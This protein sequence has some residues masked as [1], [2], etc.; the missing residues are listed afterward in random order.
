MTSFIE[1]LNVSNEDRFKKPTP[2]VFRRHKLLKAL[3]EQIEVATEYMYGRQYMRRSMRTVTDPET[4]QRISVMQQR[5]ARK[6]FWVDDQG[7]MLLQIRYGNRSIKVPDD[8]ATIV[9]GDKDQLVSLIAVMEP[10][11]IGANGASAGARSGHFGWSILPVFG[12]ARCGVACAGL[13][14]SSQGCGRVSPF[15]INRPPR[16]RRNPATRRPD[17]PV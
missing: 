13:S 8:M 1:Q 5:P 6:W 14:G 7:Q 12:R 17:R 4:Q 3:N 11:V 2:T 10:P 9:V 16:F 15:G